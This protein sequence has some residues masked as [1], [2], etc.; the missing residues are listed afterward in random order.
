[1]QKVEDIGGADPH[2]NYDGVYLMTTIVGP[3]M[4]TTTVNWIISND[5][6]N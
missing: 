4:H 5:N 2:Y 1:L 6:L 3:N